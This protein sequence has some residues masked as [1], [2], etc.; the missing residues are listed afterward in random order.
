MKGELRQGRTQGCCPLCRMQDAGSRPTEEQRL[1]LRV[2]GEGRGRR[3]R[4]GLGEQQG[5]QL[6]GDIQS[7][8]HLNM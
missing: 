7:D 6:G 2:E 8:L 4:G 1:E 5:F 3:F